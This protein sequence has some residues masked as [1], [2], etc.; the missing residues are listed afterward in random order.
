LITL[1]HLVDG[2]TENRLGLAHVRH[3]R[4]HQM[5]N[6]LVSTQFDQFGVDQQQADLVRPPGHEYRGD[7]RVQTNALTRAR[8]AGDQQVRQTGQIDHHRVAGHVLAQVERDPHLQRLAVGLFHDLA[9][10]D[11]L[12]LAVGDLDADGVLAG[13]RRDDPHAGHPQRDGQVVGQRGDFAQ[14]Q[15][16]L[17]LDLELGDHR[18]GLDF[19]HVDLEAEIGERLFQHLGLVA[20][21]LF[22]FIE[23]ERLALQ[24]QI[25]R[26][27]FVVFRTGVVVGRLDLLD[28]LVSL[29]PVRFFDP[30]R[31]RGVRL[32]GLLLV[33]LVLV[34]F[35]FVFLIEIPAGDSHRD[36]GLLFATGL[37]HVPK[38]AGFA[39]APH[40]RGVSRDQLQHPSPDC[41]HRHAHGPREQA[42]QHVIGTQQQ[43]AED[44]AESKD[45]GADGGEIRLQH[46]EARCAEVSA[47]ADHRA[48]RQLRRGHGNQGRHAQQRQQP[49]SDPQH[50]LPD[51]PPGKQQRV[52]HGQGKQQVVRA[53][54]ERAKQ[55]HADQRA[56]AA[57]DVERFGPLGIDQLAGWIR[58]VV[59]QQRG[60]QKDGHRKQPQCEQVEL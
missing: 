22:M 46:G 33:R 53:Q 48:G 52:H 51:P 42:D 14:S 34:L 47:R 15:A 18:P 44:H 8:A 10:P 13:N 20:N 43:P 12:P 36:D 17:Q 38:Q 37:R 3:N 23:T 56:G 2:P 4:V 29:R 24:Q 16:G 19:D 31:T 21:V 35:F 55:H 25:E 32:G 39:H 45:I 1:L 49:S 54:T 58:R 5:G 6:P 60:G 50:R 28:H 40:D 11:Q 30:Q 41:P 27:Q 26:G 7:H 57:T 59:A 9:E